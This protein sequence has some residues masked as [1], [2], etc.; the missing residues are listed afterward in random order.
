M[1]FG[2]YL[3][4]ER[5]AQGGMAQVYRA[6]LASDTGF[7][8]QVALKRIRRDLSDDA[9]FVGRFIDE[10]RIASTLNHANIVQVFDFGQVDGDYFLAME[11]VDGCDLGSLLDACA[12]HRQPLPLPTALYIGACVARG[13]GA[14]HQR[15]N[16][17]GQSCPVV[18]RDISP[19]NVLI[20][21]L[22]EVKVA[23]FGIAMA[24]DKEQRTKTGMILGKVRYM[25]PEQAQGASIDQRVDV[26]SCGAVLYEMLCGRPAFDGRSPQEILH[27]VIAGQIPAPSA[28][29]PELPPEVDDIVGQ[30]M[31]RQLDRRFADGGQLAR[32]LG[33]LL[34]VITPEYS[35]EDLAALVQRTVPAT[36]SPI[37][38]APTLA[39]PALGAAAQTGS[40]AI[41]QPASPPPER[42]STADTTVVDQPR[43]TP[44]TELGIA[45]SHVPPAAQAPSSSPDGVNKVVVGSADAIAAP[46]RSLEHPQTVESSL[47][48]IPQRS[49]SLSGHPEQ[50]AAQRAQRKRSS[51]IGVFL[52]V[53]CAVT[54]LTTGYL[55]RRFA[56]GSSAQRL[57]AGE[58]RS[59]PNFRVTL[60]EKPK[61]QSGHLTFELRITDRAGTPLAPGQPTLRIRCDDRPAQLPAFVHRQHAS[62]YLVAVG[63]PCKAATVAIGSTPDLFALNAR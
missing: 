13:L 27:Q 62:G 57:V 5:I 52:L 9:D 31:A 18:H 42:V 49:I 10:A 48:P 15:R 32:E 35:A 46:A 43:S 23:D 24:A 56:D 12:A 1:L 30:A 7:E 51:W 39:A 20:S 38:T 33:R 16:A 11:Y 25:A 4:K 29:N 28:L 40:E 34:H 37:A 59:S 14:A 61:Q 36:N 63:S 41:T 44:S 19:Q 45:P 54:G 8:K 6:I 17:H 53:L 58:P 60:T 3:L 22:G 21:R 55:A 50:T 26:F 2:R 47:A